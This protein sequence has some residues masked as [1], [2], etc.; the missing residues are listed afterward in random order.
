M[1]GQFETKLGYKANTS[2]KSR[3]SI[4]D[5]TLGNSSRS[6]SHLLYGKFLSFLT[7]CQQEARAQQYHPE[8]S[9][10]TGNFPFMNPENHSDLDMSMCEAG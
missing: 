4:R 9:I 10:L 2:G 1:H 8:H 3:I 7:G 5:H 6:L